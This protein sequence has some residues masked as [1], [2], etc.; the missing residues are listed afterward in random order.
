M[1][2]H[3]ASNPI[4]IIGTDASG[5]NNLSSS[6]QKI[7]KEASFIAFPKRLSKNLSVWL[8]EEKRKGEQPELFYS[9][10]PSE[11]VLW[12]ERVNGPTVVLSSGDPLWYGIGR[13]LIEKLPKKQLQFYPS[14]SSLQLGFA[15]IGRPWQDATWISLHGRDS[16]PLAKTLL[17]RPK[18]LAV[19]TDPNRGGAKEVK[20][21]LQALGLE[22][23]YD[24][25]ILERLGHAEERV[26]HLNNNKEALEDLHPLHLVILILKES[27][28]PS[29][30][31]LPIF[32][33]DD[34]LFLQHKDRPGLMTKKE[35]RVQILA[36]LELKKEGVLWDIGAGVG[37]IGLE[38]LR[39]SPN[40]SLMSIEKRKG[41]KSLIEANAKRLG[42]NPKLIIEE[43]F[44]KL[45]KDEK[46]PSEFN[47]PDRVIIGG[48]GK[49]RTLLLDSVLKRINRKGIIIIPL[50]TIEAISELKTIL[51][52]TNYQFR[53]SQHQSWRGVQI[54]NGTRF[55]P[56]NPVFLIK[57]K[58]N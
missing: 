28:T 50:V 8:K 44:L 35:I 18:A 5:V 23:S 55:S 14:P 57:C 52:K 11:L 22:N 43:E 30:Q 47:N 51:N 36:E 33:I 19:L 4:Y 42:V 7:I 34:D 25:W 13:I 9:D 27:E 1:K 54:S 49:D 15:R 24:F 16:T 53:I 39:I 37:S 58:I 32:G 17:K 56:M 2:N 38:A 21:H 45:I 26:I 12:L 6:L 31:Q 29:T 40:L 48:G 46:I 3:S 20:D 41:G 10:N